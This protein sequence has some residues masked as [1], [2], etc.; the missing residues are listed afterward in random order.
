MCLRNA[1]QATFMPTLPRFCDLHTGGSQIN[2]ALK[3]G[4]MWDHNGTYMEGFGFQYRDQKVQVE[5]TRMDELAGEYIHC[6]L[7]L[8]HALVVLPCSGSGC[9]GANNLACNAARMPDLHK[10]ENQATQNL[11]KTQREWP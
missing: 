10:S 5:L 4:V 2:T 3:V 11:H 6:H 9:A 8:A 7:S 1:I